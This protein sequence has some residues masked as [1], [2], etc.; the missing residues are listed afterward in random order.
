MP[1]PE[2]T[3]VIVNWNGAAY[4]EQLMASIQRE[5]PA[6][7]VVV[8][9]DSTDGSAAI[10]K[11][12]SDVHLIQNSRNRGFAAAANQGMALAQTSNILI[13]NADIY[14]TPGSIATLEKFLNDNK[15]AGAVAPRLSFPDG[16]LQLSCRNFPTPFTLFLYLSFLD[17][18][19]PTKY[20]L[21]SKDH[22]STRVVEQPMGA[23]LMIRKKVLDQIG[24]FD[25]TF[26]LYMEDV[27]LCERI[28]REGWKIYFYPAAEFIHDAGGSSR[29]DWYRSQLDFVRSV[30]LYFRKKGYG[31]ISVKI[32][33]VPAFIIRSIVYFF[34]GN[35]HRVTDSLKLATHSL[36][37][38]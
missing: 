16:T 4:L 18:I 14:A 28:V 2:T 33:L 8:D 30:L 1:A 36:A 19:F 7:I 15:D 25:E 34:S 21:R 6:K 26:F 35:L 24:G 37:K 13:L 11:K 38:M 5:P 31:L 27:D 29:Q 20:R 12:F 17:R 23:A 3:V 32:A 22:Q 9:N 10:L